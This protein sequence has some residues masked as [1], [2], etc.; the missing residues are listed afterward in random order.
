MLL[1]RDIRENLGPL[2]GTGAEPELEPRPERHGGRWMLGVLAAIALG[3]WSAGIA[4]ILH[5]ERSAPHQPDARAGQI[6]RFNDPFSIV[7]L[8]AQQHALVDGTMI[9]LPVVTL[10]VLVAAVVA[11][12]RK[13]SQSEA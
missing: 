1:D 2:P 5:F 3:L 10:L 6:Y 12:S 9:V 13:L 7:Y 8:S 4:L 11:I